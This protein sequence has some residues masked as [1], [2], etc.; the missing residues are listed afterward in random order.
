MSARRI[1]LLCAVVFGFSTAA[2]GS[3]KREPEIFRAD[4]KAIL[5]AQ[6][7]PIRICYEKVLKKRPDAQGMVTVK[8]DLSYGE[9]HARPTGSAYAGMGVV[10]G[11]TTAPDEVAECVLTQLEHLTLEPSD[12]VHATITWTWEFSSKRVFQQGGGKQ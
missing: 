5:D 7:E 4:V 3:V 6:S 1:V 12:K 10:K 8:F 9:I 11:M 2:C